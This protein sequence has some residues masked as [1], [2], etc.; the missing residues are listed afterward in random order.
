LVGILKQHA[1]LE[2]T[3]KETST[4]GAEL[5]A[6]YVQVMQEAQVMKIFADLANDHVQGRR[7]SLRFGVI[8]LFR[9]IRLLITRIPKWWATR[10]GRYVDTIV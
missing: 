7:W 1:A 5:G 4:R 6:Q 9:Y 3:P 2:V 8:W 10:T